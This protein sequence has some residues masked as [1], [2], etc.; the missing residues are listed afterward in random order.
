MRWLLAL[1]GGGLICM[2]MTLPV[3]TALAQSGVI[4]GPPQVT[5]DPGPPV[6]PGGPGTYGTDVGWIAVAAGFDGQGRRVAVGFS[7]QRGSRAEAEDE[8]IRACNRS[9]RGFSCRGPYAVSD[10]CLYIVPG[11]RRGG[12]S[13]GRGGTR[14]LALDQCRRGGYNCSTSKLIGGCLPGYN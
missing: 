5:R 10:G 4:S 6:A 14:Q 12:V 11:E 1:G 8:A 9:A 7:G 2:A 13:W 3:S